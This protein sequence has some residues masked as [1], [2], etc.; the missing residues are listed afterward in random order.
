LEQ[1]WFLNH[2]FF[3]VLAM[4][5]ITFLH[6]SLIWLRIGKRPPIQGRVSCTA[7]MRILLHQQDNAGME[8]HCWAK[9]D[10]GS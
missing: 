6:L 2:F 3:R 1:A 4:V 8:L 10:V 5:V 7:E 9:T